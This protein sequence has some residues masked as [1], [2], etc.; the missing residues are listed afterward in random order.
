MFRILRR[1]CLHLDC[2]HLI[3]INTILIKFNFNEP[4]G[5]LLKYLSIFSKDDSATLFNE[6]HWRHQA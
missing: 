3:V 2:D 5:K 1:Q 6:V 4:T